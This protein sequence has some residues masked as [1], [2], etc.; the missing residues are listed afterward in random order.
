MP[1]G[2]DEAGSWRRARGLREAHVRDFGIPYLTGHEMRE[3]D[4]GMI[5]DLRI[6]LIQ[7]LESA[8]RSLAQLARTRFLGG[9]PLGRTVLVLCGTGNNGAGGLVA[10]RRLHAWGANVRVLLTRS[11]EAFLGV[12]E[13]ELDIV[14]RLGIPL[15]DGR[16]LTLLPQVDLVIDAI[17]GYGLLGDPLNEAARMIELANEYEAPILSLEVPSGVDITTGEAR[18]PAVRATATLALALP[19]TGLRSRE[20]APWV[21][22]LWLGDLGV[23]PEL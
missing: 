3:V 14:E 12:P 17:L 23:P 18:D 13:H 21:G 6:E 5:E 9:N 10:A 4:R 19:K 1:V 20:A 22:E 7:V 11:P 2:R 16:G 15:S 8:G